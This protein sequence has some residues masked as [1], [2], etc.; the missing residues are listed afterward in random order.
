MNETPEAR[1]KRM[2][3]RSWRRG[4]KEMD[5]ILGPY[6]DSHLAHMTE[7]RLVLFDRLLWENDQDLLPW[8]LGQTV[9]LPDYA[10]LIAEIGVFARARLQA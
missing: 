4:T 5:M 9:P 10:E 1:L 3:M 8:V 7:A 6:A 2:K